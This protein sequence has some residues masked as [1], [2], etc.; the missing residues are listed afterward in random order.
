MNDCRFAHCMY[1]L[2]QKE[3]KSE[4]LFSFCFMSHCYGRGNFHIFEYVSMG[5]HS[6][7]GDVTHIL[8]MRSSL[9]ARHECPPRHMLCFSCNASV[10]K[11]LS[12]M[13]AFTV[14]VFLFV[15]FFFFLPLCVCSCPSCCCCRC[16][17]YG[18]S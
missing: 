3:R 14:L 13:Y 12:V 2:T 10:R 8:D 9:P 11:R 15:L 4:S 5:H 17:C 18:C 7:N 6:A 16:R 1:I